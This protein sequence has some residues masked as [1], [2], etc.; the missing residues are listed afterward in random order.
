MKTTTRGKRQ[1]GENDNKGKTTTR[2]KR[3]QGE[4]DD[5]LPLQ[6]R[7]FLDC[8]DSSGYPL[9]KQRREEKRR[10]EKRNET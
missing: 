7:A 4:G 3:Q 5:M 8:R 6:Q 2:G 10:E 1:Q 9:E